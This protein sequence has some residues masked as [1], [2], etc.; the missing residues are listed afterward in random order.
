ML[1]SPRS[2]A[3]KAG[4]LIDYLTGR[5]YMALKDNFASSQQDPVAVSNLVSA[6]V[7]SMHHRK[8]EA[9]MDKASGLYSVLSD[10]MT[11]V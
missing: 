2:E 5:A 8:L 11:T 7:Q 1:A 4:D 6:A 10:E 3:G 9:H